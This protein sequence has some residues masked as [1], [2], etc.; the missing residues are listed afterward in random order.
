MVQ[1]EYPP[2][3][4]VSGKLTKEE[5]ENP[6]LVIEEL[7]TYADVADVKEWLWDW[8]KMTVSGSFHKESRRDRGNVMD[9]YERMERL[10]EAVGVLYKQ[11]AE[12]YRL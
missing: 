3:Q 10:V 7:F 9:C 8:L 5:M 4:S 2:A 11:K 12:E 1:Q 6:Y